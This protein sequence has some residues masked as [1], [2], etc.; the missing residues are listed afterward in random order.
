[1]ASS[2]IVEISRRITRQLDLGKGMFLDADA[3]AVLTECGAVELIQKAA[4]DHLREVV[5]E[6]LKAKEPEDLPA[7]RRR[8]G[9]RKSFGTR[10]R[11]GSD[12][13]EETPLSHG[14][15][16]APGESGKEALARVQRMLDGPS[17]K[18]GDNVHVLRPRRASKVT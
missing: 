15:G 4:S 7:R 9:E 3:L 14:G 10:A 12:F 6:R 13:F 11:G 16:R 5:A 8:P 17:R 18:P 1:M 2:K